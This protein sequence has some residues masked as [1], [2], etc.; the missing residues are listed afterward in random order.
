MSVGKPVYNRFSWIKGTLEFDVLGQ[1]CADPEG[2]AYVGEQ[3]SR[4]AMPSQVIRTSKSMTQTGRTT[5]DIPLNPGLVAI[6][7][8]STNRTTNPTFLFGVGRLL[9]AFAAARS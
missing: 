1:T 9:M 4:S 7:G 2:G 3:P 5:P 6:I 8:S